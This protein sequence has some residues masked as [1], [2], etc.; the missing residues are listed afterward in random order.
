LWASSLSDEIVHCRLA[1]P[2][3]RTSHIMYMYTGAVPVVM[4][5]VMRGRLVGAIRR[6]GSYVSQ[7]SVP[8][9]WLEYDRGSERAPADALHEPFALVA[10]E[11]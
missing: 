10:D 8:R 11:W 3:G 4:R 2:F 7:F 9:M 6:H 1:R 5:H